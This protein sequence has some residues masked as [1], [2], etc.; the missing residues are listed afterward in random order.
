VTLHPVIDFNFTNPAND[1]R[2]GSVLS[3]DYTAAYRFDKLSLGFGGTAIDQF[4]NDVQNGAVVAAVPGVHGYGNR[5]RNVTVGPYL[6]YDFGR[7][8][9]NAY[10]THSVYARNT[11]AG[12]QYFVTVSLPLL[13][14]DPSK[15]VRQNSL[16][17]R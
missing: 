6:A 1:Y 4:E 17:E 10:Y 13:S 7:F 3:I 14:E 15:A 12:D 9:L 16:G 11:A 8:K 2:S 5:A